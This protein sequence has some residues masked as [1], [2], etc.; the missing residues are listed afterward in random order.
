[1]KYSGTKQEATGL[2]RALSAQEH[3]KAQRWYGTTQ[4]FLQHGCGHSDARYYY[5]TAVT[6]LKSASPG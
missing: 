4:Y 6:V 1:V 2:V 5:S 3:Y